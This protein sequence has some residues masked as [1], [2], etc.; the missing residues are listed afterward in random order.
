MR[1]GELIV[2]GIP[3]GGA[4][5]GSVS[6]DVIRAPWDGSVV[7]VAAEGTRRDLETMIESAYDARQTL[8][9]F[10]RASALLRVADEVE[11]AR[12]ELAQL[13]SQEVAK[14]ISLARAEVDRCTV[15]FRL[16][17]AHRP[18][19]RQMDL[20][21]DVRAF[22]YEATEDRRAVGVVL[23]IVPWNWPLNL[24]AHK[25][26]PALAVGCPIVVKASP[27]APLSTMA[28][29]GIVN[30]AGF[31][32]GAISAWNGPDRELAGIVA[33][34]SLAMLS[35]T[36]SKAVG[37]RLKA[38]A[39]A[40]RLPCVLELGGD[41]TCVVDEG[42]D[43]AHAAERIVWGAYAFA[44]QICISEQHARVHRSL[45]PDLRSLVVDRLAAIRLQDPADEEGLMSCVISPEAAERVWEMCEGR[46]VHGAPPEGNRLGPVLVEDPV[47]PLVNEEV[48]G[49][50]LTLSTFDD[51]GAEIERLNRSPHALHTGYFG[52]H[53]D[54]F[55][56]EIET[57]GVVLEDVP[58]VRFDALPYGGLRESGWGREGVGESLLAMTRP[59]S[60]LRR[61]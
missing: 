17:A 31:P 1:H 57:G 19:W 35:F 59:V 14:P 48:F 51:L 5:D 33:H 60:V 26:A 41:A 12:E 25:I 45:L 18:S 32:S 40:R 15:T 39:D 58:T 23:G 46:V 8:R 34:P 55:A 16:A 7:G 49:P 36:G 28:L 54:T 9:E 56:R 21:P 47:G 22:E 53:G 2:A 44:G 3:V 61:R 38:E 27:L 11:H 43:L 24:A 30:D 10:D 4:C 42:A 37:W 20:G 6:K 52:A 29:C 50:V 13:L